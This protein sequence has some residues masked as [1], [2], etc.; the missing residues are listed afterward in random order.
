MSKPP[1]KRDMISEEVQ[2]EKVVVRT[3][4]SDERMKEQVAELVK[5]EKKEAQREMYIQTDSMEKPEFTS[6]EV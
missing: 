4:R 1:S 6:A 5:Q 2:T 3:M